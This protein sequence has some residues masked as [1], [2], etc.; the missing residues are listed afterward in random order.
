MPARFVSQDRREP[1]AQRTPTPAWHSPCLPIEAIVGCQVVRCAG[2]VSELSRLSLIT[3]NLDRDDHLSHCLEG[4]ARSR[5]VPDQ[6]IV[7]AIGGGV[8][9]VPPGVTVAPSPGK[10]LALA[11]AR[12]VGRRSADGD[13][14]VFLDV[15]CIPSR[16]LIGA[17]EAAAVANDALICGEVLY[18]PRAVETGWTDRILCAEGV[19]HP[20]RTFPEGG[21]AIAPE[22]GLFWSLAFAVRAETYDRL[23]GFDEGF[24][25]YGGEDTDLAFRAA[26][27]GVQILFQGEGYAFHQ[28]HAACDPP[29]T[30]CADIVR[31][32]LRFHAR[33]GVWPMRGWLEAFAAIG[34]VTFDGTELSLR[35]LPT[36]AE[37]SAYRVPPDRPF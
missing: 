22:P 34:V 18:L 25:G 21:V 31:N 32:A 36:D 16:E 13:V 7:V 6:T 9:A 29:L 28:R 11:R 27:A 17:L 5:R 19:R 24:V 23:G 3:L 4:V 1:P 12:N 20:A 26:A 33:H 15:D 37:I 10:G 8:L 35:R 30:H 2:E 14:L